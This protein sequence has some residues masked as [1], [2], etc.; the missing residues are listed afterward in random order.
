[1]SD[2]NAPLRDIEFVLNHVADLP[3]LASFPSFE[4]ADPEF[5]S[6]LL[7]EAGRFM[8]D[9]IAPLNRDGDLVGSRRQDDGSVTTPDGFKEAYAQYVA[10]GWGGVQS[11]EEFGGGGMP[12][13][14]GLAVQEMMTAANMAFS[15]CPLLTQGAIEML[16]HHGSEDQKQT[17]LH[18][19]VTGEWSGTMNLTEPQAGSDLSA[20]RTKAEPRGDGSWSIK[21]AKIFITWGEHDMAANIIHLVLAR[22]PDAPPGTKGISTFIVPKFLVDADGSLGERNDITCVSTEH[23]L[24]IHGSPTCL[25]SYG[26]E[27]GAVGYLVG[28]ENQGMQYMFTMMN[29]ARLTV[30]LQGLAISER[31]YQQALSFA[32]ERRQ[33]RAI[34]APAGEQSLIIEH[35]DVRRM[36]LMMKAHIEAARCLLYL[37]AAAL[38]RALHGFDPEDR[39][40]GQE[41]ADLL[42]PVS[43]G[44]ATDLGVELTS[45]GIQIHGGMGY[46]EETG[47]AQHWRDSRIAPIYEGTNGIQ[48]IDLVSRKLPMRDGQVVKE[49]ITSMSAL[50]PRLEASDGVDGIGPALSDAVDALAEATEWL[51]GRRKEN[52][53]D[54]LAGATPYLRMF[55]TVAGGWLMAK[56]ALVAADHL[57]VWEADGFLAAKIETAKF[58][59]QQIL[60]TARGLLPSVIAGAEPLFAIEADHL[61]G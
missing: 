1:M 45:I 36:L 4:S 50:E 37:N 19:L 32:R 58:F 33:G 14:V 53:N 12:G 2:Y 7:G 28:Q 27:G 24:G 59:A 3:A 51:L 23:K 35:P 41:L 60:P 25:L 9:L 54:V 5:V 39:E 15:L 49:F 44:W 6:A 13:V 18:K 10:A 8:S 26:D 48:A 42:T 56:S 29:N 61:A 55:G 38:D 20:L 47:A 57:A 31:S 22:T 17:Y 43:K 16:V 11:P 34:G 30:A 40:R 52:Q 21:G 46:V